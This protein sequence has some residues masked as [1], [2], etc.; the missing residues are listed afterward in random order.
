[1]LFGLALKAIQGVA[2]EFPYKLPNQIKTRQNK[3]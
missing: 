2:M 3:Q 1:M